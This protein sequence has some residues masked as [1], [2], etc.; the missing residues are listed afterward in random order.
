MNANTLYYGDCLD[1]MGQWPDQSVDL[2]YLDPPFNSN[3]DYNMLYSNAAGGAQY[4]AFNDTWYWDEGAADRYA[5]YESAPGRPA[6]S[7]VLGMYQIFGRSGMLAY[8][9]YM[10]DRLEQLH[11]LLR[12]TGSIYLHCDPTAS[13]GLKLLMDSIFG[14]E[15][16]RNEIQWKRYGAH[17]DVGQG[18]RHFGRVHDKLLFYGKSAKST[19]DQV[20]VPLDPQ[21]VKSTYRHVDPETGRQFTTTP[22]T[23]PGGVAKGNPVYEW[24]GHTRSWRYSK[25]TMQKLHDE[26][27]I[28]YSRTGYARRKLYLD[29]SRGVPVQ[30]VWNDIPSLAGGHKERLGYPTQKPIALLERIVRASSN[31]GDLVLDP[32]CGCGSAIEA[33]HKLKRR[34]VGIDISSFAIDL[35]RNERM[36]GMRIPTRGIPQDVESARKMAREQPFA[37]ESWA[38]SRLPGFAPNTK[39]VA[40]GGVDG[41]AMLATKPEDFDSRLALAQVKGGKFSLSALRDFIGVANRDKAALGCYVTL[42][43][44]NTPAARAEVAGLGKIRVEGREFRRMSLWPIADY[45]DGRLPVLPNMT[46][47][48]TGRPI[49]PSLFR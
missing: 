40:D 3:A 12:P 29:E 26:G 34:W 36:K 22:M 15:N 33:A 19:W 13:H 45:F 28:Y 49:A 1:W 43:P 46:D 41:R 38:V 35:I 32:F 47:P 5:V 4:R 27:R 6:R 17:N 37:F 2:I 7:A 10:A 42:D 24:N 21:Y 39:Q 25:T 20:F 16:F 44:V 14:R 23:G 9:T 48:Y 8:L 31:P 30:D 11:R 18:S